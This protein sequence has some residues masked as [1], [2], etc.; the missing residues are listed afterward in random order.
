MVKVGDRLSMAILGLCAGGTFIALALTSVAKKAGTLGPPP[1]PE[2][3]WLQTANSS[4]DDRLKQLNVA[5]AGS[6]GSSS[7][8]S[9]SSSNSSSA[10]TGSGSS[11]A[12]S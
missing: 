1:K 8:G 7:G 2:W 12:T 5:P 3:P 4:F 10:G 11:A 6:S 9:D